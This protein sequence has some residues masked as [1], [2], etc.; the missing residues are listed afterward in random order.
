L[1]HNSDLVEGGSCL[2]TQP[3]TLPASSGIS[4]RI[5]QNYQEQSMNLSRISR[6]IH[7][8]AISMACAAVPAVAEITYGKAFVFGNTLEQTGADDFSL[9]AVGGAVEFVFGDLTLNGDIAHFLVDGSD[10]DFTSLLA[11]YRLP[12]D[13]HVGLEISSNDP[14]FGSNTVVQGR[15]FG[16]LGANATW[17]LGLGQQNPTG[18][19]VYSVFGAWDIGSSGRLGADVISSDGDTFFAS[20]ADYDLT[21]YTI[22]ADVLLSDGLDYATVEG[23]YDFTERFALLGEVTVADLDGTGVNILRI[24]VSYELAPGTSILAKYG[25][26][27]P[28]GF[29]NIDILTV[30]LRYEFGRKTSVL[31]TFNSVIQDATTVLSGIGTY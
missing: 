14:G 9:D 19:T 5:N 21:G 12:N 2:R 13:V 4:S 27:N 6:T 17:G 23:S 30:G 28:D 24:G 18:D 10:F 31:R 29:D 11:S 3:A 16:D 22:G 7:I 1:P 20:Y 25:R 26:L 15:I 8:A